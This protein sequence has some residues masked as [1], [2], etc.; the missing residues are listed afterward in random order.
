LHGTNLGR[1][2]LTAI[3]AVSK[4]RNAVTALAMYTKLCTGTSQQEARRFVASQRPASMQKN[5]NVFK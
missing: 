2:I 5:V 3:L 1:I 4:L